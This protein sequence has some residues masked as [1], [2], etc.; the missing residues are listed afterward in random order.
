MR[1]RLFFLLFILLLPLLQNCSKPGATV[2]KDD[3][4]S[5]E[6]Q[7]KFCFVGDPGQGTE[8]Q[9]TIT[10]ALIKEE[11]HRIAFLGDLVYP[12]GISS[13]ADPELED[14]FL[15]YYRPLFDDN[16]NLITL[17]LLGNHD[18][19]GKPGAWRNLY[20]ED[21]RFFFPNYYYFIDYGG[22]CLV[23]LDTSLY[24]YQEQLTEAAEQTQW[25]TKLQPR[26]K[27]CDVKVAMSH[28]PFKGGSYSGSKDWKGA[29]GTLKTFLD[30][31][32]IGNFDI[33]IAGHVHVLEDDGKDEGTRMLISGT[34][35]ENRGDGKSG[36]I[37]LTWN[38]ENPKRIGY[39]LRYVDTEVNVFNEAIPQEQQVHSEWDDLIHKTKLEDNIFVRFWVWLNSN[40]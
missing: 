10:E 35:G 28:H 24:F 7:V 13:T 21:E 12:K 4:L 19:Q 37:V 6:A 25:L 2:F 30:T 16:P 23:A 9:S 14:K 1:S 17:L 31:Y 11:C 18:H 34:G 29:E 5:Q 40:M 33:H 36:Y 26:L 22:L 20:K 39:R 27:D 15:K 38:P 3:R 32:V 8:F